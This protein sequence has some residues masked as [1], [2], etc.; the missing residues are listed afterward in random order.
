MIEPRKRV[1]KTSATSNTSES[2]KADFSKFGTYLRYKRISNY[3]NKTKMHLR[4]LYFLRNFEITDRELVDEIAKQFNIT[5]ESAAEELDIVRKKYGKVL[6]KIKKSLAKIGPSSMPK[7]KPPGV[8][9]DIQGK[10]PDNYKIRIAGARSREQLEEIISFI[11]VLLYLYI[12]IY[13][14]KNSKYMRIKDML[15]KFNK[16]AKRRNKVNDYVNYEVGNSAIKQT[17]SLD[18]KR[19]GFRPEEG[20]NQWSRSCQNS[21]DKIR[22]PLVISSDNTKDLIKRGYKLDEKTGNYEKK[23][24]IVD[25]GH[26]KEVII[27]AIKLPGDNGTYNFYTCDPDNN[28]KDCFIGFLSKSNNP[29][30]LCMP[31]CFKKDPSNTINKKKLAYYNQCIGQKSKVE[32]KITEEIGDKVYILQDTNKVQDG[33]FI[34][35]PK[36]LNQ[37]LNSIW[38]NNYIIKK[39]YL[40]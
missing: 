36:Y 20:Q 29:N 26:K 10:T 24:I 14:N 37:F 5:N 27:K 35:L 25:K 12:E 1:S 34:F 11:K 30:D 16:I 15:S 23:S 6:G 9:I 2:N 18:K 7:S 40:I 8:G 4:M 31:C 39:Q 21:G 13:I 3:E 33:R 28:K 19:L 32:E 22:Q 17:T 38:K